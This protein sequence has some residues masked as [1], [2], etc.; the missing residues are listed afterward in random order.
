MDGWMDMM[1]D[2]LLYCIQLHIWIVHDETLVMIHD[3]MQ[4]VHIHDV[5]GSA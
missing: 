5:D 3:T 1:I 4:V 2:D